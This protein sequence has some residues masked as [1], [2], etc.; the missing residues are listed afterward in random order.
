PA[1]KLRAVFSSGPILLWAIDRHGFVTLSEGSLL[2]EIG[3][4]P[5]EV[6]GLSIFDLY[7]DTPAVLEFTREALDG[8]SPTWTGDIHG[9]KFSGWYTP[10]YD[11]AGEVIGAIGVATDVTERV[12]LDERLRQT[13]K[14]EA[15]G[16]LAGGIA[17]DLHN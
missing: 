15:N 17:H 11:G 10:V 5:G 6:V 7:A 9:R 16:R 8:E 14:M 12:Q 13:H 3:L 1:D 2:R 4:T